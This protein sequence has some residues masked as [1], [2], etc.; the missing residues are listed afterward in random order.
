MSGSTAFVSYKRS[1]NNFFTMSFP[2][3]LRTKQRLHIN[4]KNCNGCKNVSGNSFKNHYQKIYMI[5]LGGAAVTFAQ[6]D[7]SYEVI[8]NQRIIYCRLQSALKR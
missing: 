2:S 7:S 1:G 4:K 5:H 6:R 8:C 3:H